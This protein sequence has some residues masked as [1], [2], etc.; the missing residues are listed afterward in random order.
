MM[1]LVPTGVHFLTGSHCKL[2]PNTEGILYCQSLQL[3]QV[4]ALLG[5]VLGFQHGFTLL[6]SAFAICTFA[7]HVTLPY[8]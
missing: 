1:P 8:V 6:G 5:T 7:P 3:D 2:R 4:R